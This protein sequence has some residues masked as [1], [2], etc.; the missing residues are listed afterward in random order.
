MSEPI[1]WEE[2]VQKSTRKKKQTPRVKPPAGQ[3]LAPRAEV[4]EAL[5]DYQR[6]RFYA[7]LMQPERGRRR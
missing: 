4:E 7:H 1:S 3:K 6:E 2:A 5:K